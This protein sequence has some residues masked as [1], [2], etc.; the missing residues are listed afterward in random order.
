MYN[1][2]LLK[3]SKP[4]IKLLIAD[5]YELVRIGLRTIFHRDSDFV[6]LH[7]AINGDDAIELALFQKPDVV[8]MD[9]KMPFYSGLEAAEIINN[10]NPDIKIILISSYEDE[11]INFEKLPP[12]IKGYILKDIV[13]K[14]LIEVVKLVNSGSYVFSK[15]I[16]ANYLEFKKNITDNNINY[17]VL[18]HNPFKQKGLKIK[19]L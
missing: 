7:D 5:D 16:L 13:S 19:A 11:E 15:E 10:T 4:T 3:T 14:E 17:I 2:L 1:N 9:I 6:L 8:L 12:N 18:K